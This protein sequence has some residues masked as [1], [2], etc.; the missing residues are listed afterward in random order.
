MLCSR[1]PLSDGG[2]EG[3]LSSRGLLTQNIEDAVF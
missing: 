1:G 2:K 3:V